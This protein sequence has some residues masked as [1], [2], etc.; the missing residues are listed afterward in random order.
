MIS[1][2]IRRL[3][4]L[5]VLNSAA[6]VRVGPKR[7]AMAMKWPTNTKWLSTISAPPTERDFSQ[8]TV[9]VTDSMNGRAASSMATPCSQ[10]PMVSPTK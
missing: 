2:S 4:L 9:R 7:S 3:Q 5:R 8:G 10:P 1:F 6:P